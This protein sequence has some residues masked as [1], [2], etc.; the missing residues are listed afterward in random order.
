MCTLGLEGQFILH[1]GLLEGLILG[2]EPRFALFSISG[3][4]QKME[5]FIILPSE[6]FVFFLYNDVLFRKLMHGILKPEI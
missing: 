1:T 4:V 2:F 6:T 3:E 5:Y